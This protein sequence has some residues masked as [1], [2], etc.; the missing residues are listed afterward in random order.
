[1]KLSQEERDKII[2]KQEQLRI[3]KETLKQEFVGIDGPIDEICNLLESW[4]LF[5][6]GQVR[7]LVINLWGLTGCGKT[8]LITRLFEL[9]EISSIVKFDIGDFAEETSSTLKYKLSAQVRK[10]RKEN[11]IPVFVFDEFQLGR[12]IDDE[13]MEMDRSGL[14]IIWE[15]FD[16]GKFE[17]I[18]D[19]WE[20]TSIMNIFSKLQYAL[21]EGVE[22]EN[23]KI[24]KGK[25]IYDKIFS[26][27]DDEL[28]I[29]RKAI[30]KYY[31]ENPF[32][33][34][35]DLWCIKK[36]NDDRFISELQ[37]TE[38]LKTLNGK[39]IVDF[40]EDTMERS[41][42]PVQHDL[43]SS[44]IFV[45]GNIDEAYKG[46][47]QDLD[48][49]IDAD[50]LYEITSKISITDIKKALL[51][52][53][54][55]EQ[56]SR[57]GNNHIIYKSFTGQMY[58]DL[59]ELEINRFKTKLAK[60]F[61]I[62]VEITDNIKD[63]IYKEGV[64]PTQGVRPIFSTIVNLIESYVG[65]IMV[66]S[67][68]S[69][70]TFDKLIWDLNA[71][72]EYKITLFQT[73]KKK[74][75]EHI[76][77]YSIKLK[78]ENIR[79]STSDDRQAL[80]AIHESG[81]AL[82]SI[83]GLNICPK[84]VVTKTA[85]S[86]ICGFCHVDVP[87]YESKEF[88][89][90]YL[91]VAMGGYVAEKM[92][93]G[94]DNL[95]NGSYLDMK[96]IT[97]TALCIVKKYGMIGL[98]V[99]YSFPDFRVSTNFICTDETQDEIALNLVKTAIGKT[100]QILKDNMTLLLRLGEFLSTNSRIDSESI[101][102][103]VEKY[104]SYVPKYKTKDD[105]YDFKSILLDKIEALDKKKDTKKALIDSLVLNEEPPKRKPRKIKEND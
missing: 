15:L 82:A 102:G 91:Q 71:P 44:V 59:I 46:T 73:V 52:R 72:D 89:L 92:V 84:V 97:E 40:I 24:I 4:Y 95:T 75:V 22:V 10:V 39:E 93:F 11:N 78:L 83:Y 35:D 63:L 43:S 86:G 54:R 41:F 32:V 61:D 21:K 100:E 55:A 99:Y 88:L 49:D 7:P 31:T 27:I 98:P 9:L 96:N 76:L 56:I 28:S 37:L 12:T 48:P 50:T 19:S 85:N 3:V 68:K 6:H 25:V 81:H 58:K 5:P 13:G 70:I 17:M 87:E 45:I 2:S 1:M 69:N 51:A 64:F 60:K 18:E 79:Q 23:G 42:R 38:Y 65:K 36:L 20:N 80:T 26:S 67:I 77:N 16:S 8:A 101:K 34:V 90:N 30:K 74:T 57:L 62:E 29:S 47:T 53:F 105:Y 103:V 14:R 33:P 94:D 104:G 66:D